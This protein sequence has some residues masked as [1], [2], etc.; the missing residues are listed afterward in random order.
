T[1][2]TQRTA[3]ATPSTSHM[4]GPLG[5]VLR[6]ALRHERVALRYEDAVAVPAVH[7]DVAADLEEIGDAAVVHDRNR[8]SRRAADVGDAE[9][10]AAA[11]V[12][13]PVHRA[14][15]A[16]DQRDLACVPGEL[17]RLQLRSA[18]ACDRHVEQEDREH[19]RDRQR[20]DEAH[21]PTVPGH[22]AIVDAVN[23]P[24]TREAH[25]GPSI[26]PVTGGRL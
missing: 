17:A 23:R 22:L 6:R 1:S 20:Q 8:R 3:R 5:R 9:T 10:Q 14:D 18:P 25:R 19:T 11:R 24:Y 4:L 2:R 26:R 15:D 21:T 16:P 7:D 12:A 13:G